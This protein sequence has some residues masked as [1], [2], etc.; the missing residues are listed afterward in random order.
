[1]AFEMMTFMQEGKKGIKRT[2]R[3]WFDIDTAFQYKSGDIEEHFHSAQFNLPN[4]NARR[5]DYI[6]VKLSNQNVIRIVFA[7]PHPIKPHNVD[8]V[9]EKLEWLKYMIN[10]NETF[11]DIRLQRHEYYWIYRSSSITP[12]S[13]E[14]KKCD[15]RGLRI[16]SVP[17]RV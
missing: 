7:E 2:Y 5:W 17:L 11:A 13:K 9:L 8:E 3:D 16:S 6:L 1:M 15:S 14:K 10:N 12:D 4:G